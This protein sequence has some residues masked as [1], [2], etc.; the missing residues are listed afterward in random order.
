MLSNHI[1]TRFPATRT[2]L[3]PIVMFAMLASA[4]P[5]HAQFKLSGGIDLANFAGDGAPDG[6]DRRELGLGMSVGVVSFGP[7]QLVAEVYY[8][9]KGAR[10]MAEFNDQLVEGG[11]S[12]IGL[13]Y[14]E[15]PLL[16]RLNGPVFASRFLP[17]V[18]AGPAFAWRI[19][20]SITAQQNGPSQGD[21]EDLAGENFEETLRN[22]EQGLVLGGGVDIAVFSFAAINLDARVT[23][24][25]SRIT[26][27]DATGS[28]ITNRSFSLMLGYTIGLPA[29]FGGSGSA[30]DFPG[31]SFSND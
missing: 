29:A 20:C 1:P 19:N 10:D 31:E 9:Q 8:R 14:I 26:Q 16:V 23:Q 28:K 6:E 4:A 15:I 17:Y 27:E 2:F 25:L 18:Q 30:T 5:A 13:D 7:A 12:E 21:C 24:G 3:L 11:S 22:Y